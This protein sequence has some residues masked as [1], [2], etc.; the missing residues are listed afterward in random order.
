M[1]GSVLNRF[2]CALLA[3]AQTTL[4]ARLGGCRASARATTY[5]VSG[6]PLTAIELGELGAPSAHS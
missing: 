1:P 6:A 5:A 4:L 2:G 3:F